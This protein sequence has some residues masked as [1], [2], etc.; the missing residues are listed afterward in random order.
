LRLFSGRPSR[1][2][3]RDSQKTHMKNPRRTESDGGSSIHRRIM[4][5]GGLGVSGF[6]IARSVRF[7]SM[8]G[9]DRSC[10]QRPSCRSMASTSMRPF[11]GGMPSFRCRSTHWTLE[12]RFHCPKVVAWASNRRRCRRCRHCRKR[13]SSAS[14]RQ[15]SLRM[16]EAWAWASIRPSTHRMLGAWP[17]ASIHYRRYL[18][19]RPWQ[20]WT[21]IRPYFHLPERPWAS[22]R[23][24]HRH[25]SSGSCQASTSIRRHH[26]NRWWIRASGSSIH[27]SCRLPIEEEASTSIRHPG[28]GRRI[29]R[30]IDR[31][32][33]DSGGRR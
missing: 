23:H 12:S 17:S 18:V 11:A 25:C 2:S 24:R 10:R 20:D 16:S 4:Y 27:R 13:R 19:G 1:S 21:S 15:P 5:W 14:I 30:T 31:P 3:N 29:E 9:N 26:W 22:S 33:V 6:S 32:G 8:V 7:R 28:V